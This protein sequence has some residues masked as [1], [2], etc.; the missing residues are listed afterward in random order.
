MIKFRAKIKDF[1]EFIITAICRMLFR[2]IPLK[3]LELPKIENEIEINVSLTTIPE[4]IKDLWI[5]IE[6]IMR[7]SKKPNRV[8]LYLATDQ[9]IDIEIPKELLMLREKGLEIIY[10][11]DLKPHKKY[12]YTMKKY[13]NAVTITIDDDSIYMPNTIKKLVK[14]YHKFPKCISCLRAHEITFD[15]SGR[16]QKYINWNRKIAGRKYDPSLKIMAV[17]KGGVLYPPQILPE[18]TF[19]IEKIKKYA[20]FG[21][22]LWLKVMELKNGICVVKADNGNGWVPDIYKSQNYALY[23]SNASSSA[24]IIAGENRNDVYMDMLWEEYMK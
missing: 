21:D 17:G 13:P 16:P 22:D 5:V 1:Y 9:F 6:S 12:Y 19:C 24:G 11:E 15:E 23:L 7:Q 14:S 4:R 2:C 20:L 10:C 3:K 8:L 18:E